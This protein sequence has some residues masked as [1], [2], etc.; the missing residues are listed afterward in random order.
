MN[1]NT[2]KFS[3]IIPPLLTPLKADRSLNE[4]ELR[5]YVDWLIGKG[6]HGLFPNGTLGEF[7]RIPK[8]TR[9]Q[10]AKVVIDQ[11]AGRVPVIVGAAEENP[12]EILRTM[13]LYAQWGAH[14]VSILPPYYYRVSER[15]VFLHFHEIA[16][17]ASID[18][19]VYNF[20]KFATDISID[21]LQSLIFAS[22]HFIG[23]KDT[24]GDLHFMKSL[25]EKVRP[26]RKG[27][28]V[29]TG[30]D[31]V[32]YPM[33][34][35]GADG[36][37]LSMS[38]IVPE[39][40]TSIFQ[41]FKSGNESK[42]QKLQNSILPL[43]EKVCSIEEFPA[44]FRQALQIR[45]FNFKAQPVSGSSWK[46]PDHLVQKLLLSLVQASVT[47][48]GFLKKKNTPSIELKKR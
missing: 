6:V 23:I 38:N 27:F 12:T 29:F 41:S 30:W 20:P 21:T 33:L 32:L 34:K 15:T 3:G 4:K 18:F 19:L 48:R 31:A 10:I 43:F 37:I 47:K 26:L 9:H 5:R 14:A 25:L 28:S 46:E 1:S 13:E 8:T 24:S 44:G 7:I 17:G 42:A 36:G 2:A 39:I 11:A 16:K 40:M 22:P 35:Q 45:G